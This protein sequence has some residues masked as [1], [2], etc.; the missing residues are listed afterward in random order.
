MNITEHFMRYLHF[1]YISKNNINGNLTRELS[2][3]YDYWVYARPV[4][5]QISNNAAKGRKMGKKESERRKRVRTSSVLEFLK[6]N[7]LLKGS[8]SNIYETELLF[9]LE[10]CQV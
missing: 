5:N 4:L 10:A 6:Y 3:R 7:S 1:K 8:G 9:L 2:M